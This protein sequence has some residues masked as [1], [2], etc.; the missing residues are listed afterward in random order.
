M[1]SSEEKIRGPALSEAD[2]R[3]FRNFNEDCMLNHLKIVG[4]FFTWNNK[5]E[6]DTRVWSKLDRPLVNDTWINRFNASHAEFLLPSFSDHSP[7][8]ISIYEDCMQ[9]E[10]PFKFFKI[11]IKYPS[12]SP[13]VL[14]IWKETIGGYKM[15][16]VYK[17]LK[18]LRESLKVLNK[19]HFYNIREQVQRARIALKDAQKDLQAYPLN[20][21][22]A[23]I[24]WNLQGDRY[25]S[26][27]HAIVKSNKHNNRVA[28]LYNN[29]GDRITNGEEIVNE[30]ITYYKNLM[31]T[32]VNT[33]PPDRDIIKS[34][35]CLYVSQA[36]ALS[37]PVT[38]EEIKSAIFS[39]FENKAP[40]PDGYNMTFLNLHDDLLLFSKGD[41]YSVQKLYQCVIE[42]SEILVLRL[43]LKN[44][45]FS[46]EVWMNQMKHK[47]LSYAGR[48][49]VIK[50]VI[51]GIQIFWTLNFVLPVNVLQRID[52]LYGKFLWSKSSQ[53]PRPPLVSSERVCLRKEQG[54]LGVFLA[55]VWNVASALR[56]IWYIH[57]NKELL[58]IKWIHDTYLKHRDIWHERNNRIFQQKSKG[59]DTL[60]REI[61]MEILYFVL[62]SPDIIK[63]C[64]F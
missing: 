62:N 23:R 13:T 43:T 48:L 37:S 59:P 36:S 60:V 46:L 45:L 57:V 34:S 49:Q 30:L 7:A 58:W 24:A 47:N 56:S 33:I 14:D 25:T 10:K 8:L 28:V 3:D 21:Q 44:V 4:Y 38:K 53:G 51:L 22:K 2:T 16:S 26:F 18:L 42:F 15:F 52:E 54:R 6:S 64:L 1:I 61:K 40:D 35:P 9:G 55:P 63:D 19:K 31:G 41:H 32:T 39:I 11:W 17:K 20:P 50:S 12:F 5:Q 29:L 27:F